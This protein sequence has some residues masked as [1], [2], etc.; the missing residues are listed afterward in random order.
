M[1]QLYRH[2]EKNHYLVV[3][4]T[5]KSETAQGFYVK[6]GDGGVDLEPIAHLYK[7]QVFQLAR[8]LGVINEIINRPPTPDTYSLP[9]TDKDFYFCIDYSLLDL[10][11]YAYE[12]QIPTSTV[13]QTLGLDE[14]Q[15]ERAWRDIRAKEA[16]TWHLRQLPPSLG[17]GDGRLP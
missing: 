9:V 17:E 11:L 14:A 13:S 16:A 8:H 2:A 4:T 5:N 7:T 15:V 12:A 10:L 6:F 3:G 1:I